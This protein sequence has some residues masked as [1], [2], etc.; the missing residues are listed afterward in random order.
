MPASSV[1]PRVPEPRRQARTVRDHAGNPTSHVQGRGPL[2]HEIPPVACTCGEDA[3]ALCEGRLDWVNHMRCPQV[4]ARVDSHPQEAASQ[5]GCWRCSRWP[6]AP[7]PRFTG[8]TCCCHSRCAPWIR[9]EVK[10]AANTLSSSML[11]RTR[12]CLPQGTSSQGALS[13]RLRCS[14]RSPKAL[15]RDTHAPPPPPPQRPRSCRYLVRE[16]QE[17]LPTRIGRRA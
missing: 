9:P 4:P 14:H 5:V 17:W 13:F 10:N 3:Q 8:K 16:R 2:R 6:A 12:A 7:V 11:S 1:S 15:H